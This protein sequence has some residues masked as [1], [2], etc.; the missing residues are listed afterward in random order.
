MKDNI[1]VRLFKIIRLRASLTYVSRKSNFYRASLSS[2]IDIKEYTDVSFSEVGFGSYLGR[3]CS[4]RYSFIGKFCS[5]GDNVVV[6]SNNHPVKKYVS[7]HPAFHRPNH[8]LMKKLMMDFEC[9]EIYPEFEKVYL[10][11]FR[12]FVGNDVW[13]GSNVTII[14]GVSIGDG[15]VIACGSVVTRDVEPYSIVGGAP[16][17][18]IKFRFNAEE[19]EALLHSRWWDWDLSRLKKLSSRFNN[20]SEFLELL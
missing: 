2:N 7:T 11:R 3:N 9:D 15:A 20:V 19:I 6:V 14:E 18:L 10:E 16:A 17:K 4:I 13:I 12:T 5:I 1:V 8:P